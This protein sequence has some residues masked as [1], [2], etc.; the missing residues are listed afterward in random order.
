MKLTY[1]LDPANIV[2]HAPFD[3]TAPLLMLAVVVA[4][5]YMAAEGVKLAREYR[6]NRMW[7]PTYQTWRCR[8]GVRPDTKNLKANYQ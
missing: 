3:P 6:S 8:Y 7:S 5:G 4:V 2:W 1:T